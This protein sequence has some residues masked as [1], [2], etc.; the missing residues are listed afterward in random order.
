MKKSFLT[1]G[2][3]LAFGIA[4]A[5]VNNGGTTTQTQSQTS[6]NLRV[7]ENTNRSLRADVPGQT[8]TTGSTQQMDMG[9]TAPPPSTIAGSR[10]GEPGVTTA[11]ASGGVPVTTATPASATNGTM[12]TAVETPEKTT[13]ATT[14]TK[15]KKTKRSN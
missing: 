5:Q 14:T 9:P 1:L 11:P 6:N 2:A 12:T 15:S 8:P 4:S 3:I 10:A 7:K 13:T